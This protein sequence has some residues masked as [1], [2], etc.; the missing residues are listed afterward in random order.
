[1]NKQTLLIGGA[2]LSVLLVFV[3]FTDSGGNE[4]VEASKEKNIGA[5]A[6]LPPYP[7]PNGYA[8]LLQAADH[9]KALEVPVGELSRA[10]MEVYL[11]SHQEALRIVGE[12]FEFNSRVILEGEG[13]TPEF[14]RQNAQDLGRLADLLWIQSR[15][16]E[17]LVKME[18]AAQAAL[19]LIRLGL[20]VSEGG[21]GE[22]LQSGLSF[23]DR[24]LDRLQS[25]QRRL[26]RD[27]VVAMGAGLREMERERP[28]V[29]ALR[30]WLGTLRAL[31]METE[32][33]NWDT[34]LAAWT[35]QLRR[36][37][38]TD[39]R[40]RLRAFEMA[41]GT[42]P[43]SLEALGSEGVPEIPIDPATGAVFTLEAVIE[44]A[45]QVVR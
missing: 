21:Q 9:T 45:S 16:A 27:S 22:D 38:I 35:D 2:V 42:L 15:R 36:L 6:S 37:R 4:S 13:V 19:G 44:D 39:L 14:R 10:A 31:G 8:L 17:S 7:V 40:Y 5:P 28:S 18:Q 24:G 34:L 23:Q 33:S 32:E 41:K 11:S 1:M 20:M 12:A 26:Q 30:T 3:I 43:E 29:E 25:L